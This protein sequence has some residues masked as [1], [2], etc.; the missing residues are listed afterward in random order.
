MPKIIQALISWFS[1]KPKTWEN[2][3]DSER[4]QLMTESSG[5]VRD[6]LDQVVG[7]EVFDDAFGSS[8]VNPNSSQI[9]ATTNQRGL[10]AVMSRR[11]FEPRNGRND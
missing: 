2:L 11:L 9:G 4:K 3:S 10:G 5:N 6:R 1:G 8:Q 7:D